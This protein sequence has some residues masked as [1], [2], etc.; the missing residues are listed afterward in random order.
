MSAA[1]EI[2]ALIGDARKVI[3]AGGQTDSGGTRGWAIVMGY[4][5][6][7]L[8]NALVTLEYDAIYIKKIEGE[9]RS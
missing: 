9:A 5:I 6:N 8:D 2:R 1:D 3:E 4:L 7:E